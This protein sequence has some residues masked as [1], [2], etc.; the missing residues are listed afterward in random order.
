MLILRSLWLPQERAYT[1][2]VLHPWHLVDY[3]EKGQMLIEIATRNGRFLNYA[4]RP[5]QI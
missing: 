5:H 3:L 4:V 1:S 2:P